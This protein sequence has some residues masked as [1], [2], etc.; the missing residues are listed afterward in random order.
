[1]SKIILVRNMH[2][3]IPT[4]LLNELVARN[5]E[6]Y[7][8]A[9]TVTETARLYAT[10]EI[11]KN[12]MLRFVGAGKADI[13]IYD[14][15]A[16]TRRPGKKA[17]F[18]GEAATGN[19]D[20]DNA[21][22]YTRAV[23]EYFL[24]V[25]GRNSIDGSGMK[26]ISSVNYGRGYN[27]AYWDG[28]QMTYG[29]GDGTI[30]S[31][32]VIADVCGH[33]IAH[34]VTQHMANI[35]YYGQSGALNEHISDVFGEAIEMYAK[36]IPT[37]QADWVIG[38]GI[39]VPGINGTGIRNMLNPGTAYNDKKLGKD[40]QPG[41]MKDYVK[42]SGD[43]GGV[44]YNSGIPNRAFALFAID[45]GGNVW[46]KATK[47]WYAALANAGNRPSFAS[48]SHQTLEACKVLGTAEDLQKLQ[49]AW[50][51]VGVIPNAKGLDDLTPDAGDRSEEE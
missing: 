13:E 1:M 22:D 25:H 28:R 29:K 10:S 37:A 42:T 20:V 17:R 27:N 19:A 41:H 6:L 36:K 21:Y 2:G 33:E 26:L 24:N 47:I 51:A 46:D 34:G 8:F 15:E 40:P 3:F 49:K 18:E 45:L 9:D 23:R 44:H 48:F 5:P 31:S 35:E 7:Q 30:F 38:N 50:A 12:P 16:S 11:R 4:Y 39:F 43:N 14:C 32:F